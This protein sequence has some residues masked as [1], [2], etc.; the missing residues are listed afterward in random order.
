MCRGA[1]EYFAQRIR[2]LHCPTVENMRICMEEKVS[3]IEM[4]ALVR[5]GKA[6]MYGM[7]TALTL[8]AEMGDNQPCV[9]MDQGR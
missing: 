9:L 2:L 6:I 3:V 4:G 8:R 1:R 7:T 5:L